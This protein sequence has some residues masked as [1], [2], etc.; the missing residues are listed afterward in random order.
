MGYLIE[1]LCIVVAGL[2]VTIWI[3]LHRRSVRTWRLSGARNQSCC[4]EV[5][6]SEDCAR[7]LQAAYS[8][9]YAEGMRDTIAYPERIG[10]LI[11]GQGPDELPL[12]PQ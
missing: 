4:L 2:V 11:R 8:A 12:T 5:P 10:Q 6:C 1:F 7:R 3:V 9:R